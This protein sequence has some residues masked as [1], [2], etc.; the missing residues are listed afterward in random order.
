VKK[1]QI[2]NEITGWKPLP[3]KRAMLPS[4]I[5]HVMSRNRKLRAIAAAAIVCGLVAFV[6]WFAAGETGANVR[7]ST[8]LVL[9]ADTQKPISGIRVRCYTGN[10]PTLE[11]SVFGEALSKVQTTD[12]NGKAM[13]RT[14]RP[15]VKDEPV[16]FSFELDAGAA[17]SEIPVKAG[18]VQPEDVVCV[19]FI[20][21]NNRPP[22]RL[23]SREKD[24]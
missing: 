23:K 15:K 12:R 22:A 24:E 2:P 21:P 7:E 19:F 16:R 11:H 3:T 9:D 20:R 4:R 14:P 10:W 18:Y 17:Y 13:F 6:L 5:R 8:I 1:E